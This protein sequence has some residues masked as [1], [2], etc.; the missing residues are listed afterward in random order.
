MTKSIIHTI[1]YKKEAIFYLCDRVNL[2]LITNTTAPNSILNHSFSFNRVR[3]ITSYILLN[4][5]RNLNYE[6]TFT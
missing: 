3:I 4:N 2:L 1:G 5:I 6:T